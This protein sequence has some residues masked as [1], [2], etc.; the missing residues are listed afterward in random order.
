MTA[1]YSIIPTPNI[2]GREAE[3]LFINNPSSRGG[4]GGY[5]VQMAEHAHL[6]GCDSRLLVNIFY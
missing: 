6:A 4:E 2:M 3:R 5:A 1:E